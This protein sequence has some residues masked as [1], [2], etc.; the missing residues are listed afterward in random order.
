MNLLEKGIWDNIKEGD[1][2]SFELLFNTYYKGLRIYAMDILKNR[3]DAE[4]I[5]LDMFTSL[6][7]NKSNIQIHTSLKAYLYRS[8]HNRCINLIRRNEVNLRKGTNYANNTLESTD[9]DI[10]GKDDSALE[11]LIVLELE[12][13]IKAAIEKLPEQCREVFNLSR[14]EQMKIRDIA[15]K[16]NL[17]ES[18][19]KTQLSRAMEKLHEIL[20]NHLD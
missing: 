17:A 1:L 19:V 2:K 20:R 18:T 16:L 10:A 7:D 8:I 9:Q 5:V 14:F 13:N 12:N 11:N 4:E 6:W 15:M 3:E